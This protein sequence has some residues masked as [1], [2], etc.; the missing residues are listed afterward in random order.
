[1]FEWRFVG[2]MQNIVSSDTSGWRR[3]AGFGLIYGIVAVISAYYILYFLA[4]RATGWVF[5]LDLAAPVLLAC[6]AICFHYWCE[7]SEDRAAYVPRL[8]LWVI[9]GVFVFAGAGRSTLFYQRLLGGT[10]V[11]ETPVTM[12]WAA[13]GAVIGGLFGIYNAERRRQRDQTEHLN[14]GLTVLQRVLR[15][16][17][18]TGAN[19]IDGYAELLADDPPEEA[20]ESHVRII[21]ARAAK[22]ARLSEN[23]RE[24]ERVFRTGGGSLTEIDVASRLREQVDQ[25]DGQYPEADVV[26]DLPGTLYV[27]AS[28]QIESALR[29]LIENAVEHNDAEGPTVHVSVGR[30]GRGGRDDVEIR[31]ADDGPGIPTEERAVIES[32]SETPLEHSTGLGLWLVK[33]I[34]DASDGELLI[35][36][37]EPRGAVVVIR[38]PRAP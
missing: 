10:V 16:D 20:V 5:V 31:I 1:M 17:I 11:N 3:I 2:P 35:R 4:G 29:N 12:A 32:G 27:T 26:E 6:G 34:V 24:I 13:G 21:R 8:A 7:G 22:I 14:Q 9:V 15:H 19:V 36:D 30:S 23:A 28:N 38:L 37:N 18:L 25:L 33:W